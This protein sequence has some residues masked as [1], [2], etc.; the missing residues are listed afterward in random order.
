MAMHVGQVLVPLKVIVRE[1]VSVLL[2]IYW[3][4]GSVARHKCPLPMEASGL[5]RKPLKCSMLSSR[6]SPSNG[7]IVR[8]AGT[9]LQAPVGRRCVAAHTESCPIVTA[10]ISGKSFGRRCRGRGQVAAVVAAN[11]CVVVATSRA[12]LLRYDFSEGQAPGM[13][14]A[15]PQSTAVTRALPAWT[16]SPLHRMQWRRW[17]S[18][19]VRRSCATSSWT[20]AHAMPSSPCR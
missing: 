7:W 20:R 3:M 8:S 4:T 1:L 2:W 12:Y 16:S 14:H 19:R 18:S 9:S 5:T 6:S 15:L 11:D 10:F 13:Q 17:S